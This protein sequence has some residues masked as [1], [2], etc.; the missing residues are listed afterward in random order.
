MHE[1]LG[2]SKRFG[3]TCHPIRSCITGSPWSH[4]T[5]LVKRRPQRISGVPK[6]IPGTAT[7]NRLFSSLKHLLSQQANECHLECQLWSP[8][9]EILRHCLGSL[10]KNHSWLSMTAKER[11]RGNDSCWSYICHLSLYQSGW[12][13]VD[14]QIT[15][16]SRWPQQDKFIIGSHHMSSSASGVQRLF[17]SL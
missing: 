6:C 3:H 10:G 1:N 4:E 9:R 17:C 5:R 11:G 8:V 14:W 12:V 13:I 15:P 2:H 7:H 16:W